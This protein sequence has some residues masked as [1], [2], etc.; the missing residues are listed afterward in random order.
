[1]KYVIRILRRAVVMSSACAFW[2]AST[3]I[4][5]T[6]MPDPREWVTRLLIGGALLAFLGAFL[7]VIEHRAVS[8]K[9]SD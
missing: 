2:S 7:A 6:M 8:K 4:L 9:Q 5:A 1:M 3:L